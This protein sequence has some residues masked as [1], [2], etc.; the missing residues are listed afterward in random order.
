MHLNSL[1]LMFSLTC[2]TTVKGSGVRRA[3]VGGGGAEGGGLVAAGGTLP[4]TRARHRACQRSDEPAGHL[5][6]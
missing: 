3:G 6:G 4:L 2:R 1:R 5:P